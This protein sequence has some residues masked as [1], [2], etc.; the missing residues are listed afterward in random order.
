M[1]VVTYSAIYLASNPKVSTWIDEYCKRNKISMMSDFPTTMLT[2][3][4]ERQ[5]KCFQVQGNKTFEF[6]EFI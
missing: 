1:I 3:R 5:V 6:F 2:F 4:S